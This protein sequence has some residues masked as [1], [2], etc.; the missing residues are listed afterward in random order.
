MKRES[1]AA[2]ALA[3][4]LLWTSAAR[5]RAQ[6]EAAAPD[7]GQAEPAMLEGPVG[8]SALVP[9]SPQILD[10]SLQLGLLDAPA[11]VSLPM[12]THALAP[13]AAK[14]AVPPVMSAGRVNM[15][16]RA[17]NT[18]AAAQKAAAAAQKPGALQDLERTT[19]RMSRPGASKGGALR[20]LLDGESG[21][22]GQADGAAAFVQAPA[23]SGVRLWARSRFHAWRLSRFKDEDLPAALFYAD[24]IPTPAVKNKVAGM[25]KRLL[26]RQ[27]VDYR[28]TDKNRLVITPGD[29]SRLNRFAALVKR[30]F[31]ADVEFWADQLIDSKAGAY[32]G[33]FRETA[34]YAGGLLGLPAES[35]VSGRP[36]A[37][38][39]AMAAHEMVHMVTRKRGFADGSDAIHG[40]LMN[41][42]ALKDDPGYAKY[43][44][45]DELDAYDLTQ[46]L[47][48][49]KAQ[50]AYER[51]ARGLAAPD[52]AELLEDAQFYCRRLRELL[53][54]PPEADKKLLAM[55]GWLRAGEGKRS[56]HA[57][58]SI[59]FPDGTLILR[60]TGWIKTAFD[61]YTS[62]LKYGFA[63]RGLSAESSNQDIAAALE[64][65]AQE[66]DDIAANK[67]D[68]LQRVSPRLESLI[69]LLRV[70]R[71][72]SPQAVRRGFA[73]LKAAE[74][75]NPATESQR[76]SWARRAS[77][78]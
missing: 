67:G 64:R 70:R 24:K 9:V 26:R 66:L 21:E 30:Q 44:S 42:P 20:G 73:Q 47:L 50:T 14:A 6:S 8:V 18:A 25:A 4:A 38:Q 27:G 31:S 48:V 49:A 60:P 7:A 69:R 65:Q 55:A 39:D 17:A 34:A 61:S 46:R 5:A 13:A 35:V 63:A 57:N 37:P 10:S 12:E 54:A 40:W 19:R 23:L 16:E 41:A 59:Y 3:C 33:S 15:P 74:H 68:A 76:K 53:A 72:P 28:E 36:F 62:G 58:L 2:A 1:Y 32:H 29:G 71:R 22:D 75:L 56:R 43:L 78:H 51:R 11:P 52:P 77:G 45:L